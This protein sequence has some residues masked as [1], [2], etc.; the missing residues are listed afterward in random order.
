MKANRMIS[1]AISWA[2]LPLLVIVSLLTMSASPQENANPNKTST[3]PDPAE[4]E[5]VAGWLKSHAIPLKSVEAGHGFDDLKT[6]KK[7]LKNARIVGLGEATHGSREFFQFKSRMLEFLVKEM[8]FNV[9]AIEA[10]Y[11]ACMNIN[12]Y[13]LFGK[14]DRAA[15]LASQK[16]WTW[17]TNEVSEMIDWM[18]D[19]N[20]TAPEGR[21]VKFLGFDLQHFEQGLDL[22][23]AYL[24]KVA[25]EYAE[26]AEATYKP[27]RLSVQD[28]MKRN[29][30]EISQTRARLLELIGFL[31]SN[32]TRFVRQTSASEFELV[33]QHAR[34]PLQFDDSYIRAMKDQKFKFSRDYYMAENIEYLMKTEG[35]ETKMVV[36]AHNGHIQTGNMGLLPSM[37]NYL[38]KFFGDSYYALGFSFNEGGFQARDMSQKGRGALTEFALGPAPAGSIDW[39]FAQPGIANYVVDFRSA[40]KDGKVAQWLASTLRMRSIGSGFST[41]WPQSN[42][43]TPTVLKNHYDG[44]IFIAKTTRSRPNPTGMRGPMN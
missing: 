30:E 36:W 37:G 20:R 8:G 19:Y 3:L 18:R 39:H 34:I 31:A 15:A 21:K 11:P 44:M 38:R 22:V 23:I 10:S 16:F 29:E 13:V 35:P 32:Q 14:G 2:C 33:M 12:D 43:M 5:A 41:G 7:I 9:F 42:T 26:T 28:Y 1:R 6:L 40:P 27:L 4:V 25:P 17:D 24:K